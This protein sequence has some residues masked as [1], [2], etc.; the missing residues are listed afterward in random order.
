MKIEELEE[1][2]KL[3]EELILREEAAK[4]YESFCRYV[5]DVEPARHH[6][7][8]IKALERILSGETKRL[9]IMAPPGSAKSTYST[10]GL[11]AFFV[12]I[13]TGLIISCS[14]SMGLAE[15]FG[16]KVRNTLFSQEYNAVF[17]NTRVLPDNRAASHWGTT[18]GSAY[19]AAGIGTGIAGRRGDLALL[20][21]PYPSKKEAWSPAYRKTVRD[22]FFNDLQPRL[23]PGAPIILIQTRWHPEDLA[24]EIITR[25]E[26]GEIVG[27]E[28]EIINLVALIEN[29][30]DK[31]NDPLNRDLGEALWPEWQSAEDLRRIRDSFPNHSEWLAL[32]Q[33]RPTNPEGN[34]I[35]KNWLKY[36]SRPIADEEIKYRFQTWD[37]AS[38]T[39][40]KSAFTVGLT[41][42]VLKNNDY[43]VEDMIRKKIEF[44]DQLRIIR[45][46][47][48][49]K[50]SSICYIE[51]KQTGAS[52][53]QSLKDKGMN[54]VACEPRG[55]GDK[56]VRF[57]S[58]TPVI[59]SGRLII[60]VDASWRKDFES[61]VTAF[62][63]SRYADIPDAL[64]QGLSKEESRLQRRVRRGVAQLGRR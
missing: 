30:E 17:P 36:T 40:A 10:L 45:D 8:M 59:E 38:S 12:G 23:H 48:M 11:P 44:P 64:S 1:E 49:N 14:H 37:T 7:V 62:P 9:L 55:Q 2:E 41:I 63:A 32:Y 46:E 26:Q 35:N 54:L 20:D 57:E 61:E 4:D 13:Q 42:A 28:W 29:E 39:S 58:I 19:M 50:N 21:D 34:L 43:F 52:L 53:L 56:E 16:R 51:N 25:Q 24:G 5:L 60:P 22:W 31:E 15:D 3:L 33:Q 18:N 6:K 47:Y 27:Y